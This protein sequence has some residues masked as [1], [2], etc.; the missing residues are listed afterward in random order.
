[1]FVCARQAC[2]KHIYAQY[3]RA[4]GKAAQKHRKSE[5][6]QMHSK[7]KKKKAQDRLVPRKV[8]CLSLGLPER[9]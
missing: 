7:L 1:M 2:I 5:Q 8:V 3:E 6:K 4:H 9:L